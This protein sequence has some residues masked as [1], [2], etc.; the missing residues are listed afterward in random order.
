MSGHESFDQAFDAAVDALRAGA[1]MPDVLAA[2]P[3]HR[4]EL[5]PLLAVAAQ[6]DAAAGVPAPSARLAQNFRMVRAAVV[7]AQE[8][9]RRPAPWWRRPVTF[10]SLSLPA[11][12]LALVAIGAAGAAA[13]GAVAVSQ[14]GVPAA[15][16][17]I[18]TFGAVGGGS[19]TA[20][21]DAATAPAGVPGAGNGSGSGGP[22]NAGAPTEGHANNGGRSAASGTPENPNAPASVIVSGTIE[23]AHGG[24]FTLR[25]ADGDWHVNVDGKTTVTGTIVNG[26]SATITGTSTA[27]KELHATAVDVAAAPAT[28]LPAAAA[29]ETPFAGPPGNPGHTPGAGANGNGN[30]TPPKTPASGNGNGN[31]TPPKTPASGNPNAGSNG[32][33]GG[34]NGVGSAN[35]NGGGHKRT[36]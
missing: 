17:H 15:V 5:L 24:V 28:P 19:S 31:G 30:G 9:G 25:T 21:Q 33:P 23:D 18:V 36:P 22:G 2:H 20:H 29:T 26:A 3:D 6:V 13:G 4:A 7:E 34:W 14:T 32:P 16:E 8:S 11:G 27:A 1:H 10:A 35:S 12:V